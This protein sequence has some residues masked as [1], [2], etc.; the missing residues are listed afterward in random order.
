MESRVTVLER[1]IAVL[2]RQMQVILDAVDTNNSSS[3]AAAAVVEPSRKGLVFI[4]VKP[5]NEK[6][7]NDT[8]T[9]L[10]SAF[11]AAKIQNAEIHILFSSGPRP[12]IPSVRPSRRP[13]IGVVYGPSEVR[14]DNIST[15]MK[16]FYLKTDSTFQKIDLRAEENRSTLQDVVSYLRE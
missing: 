2:K 11:D 7:F 12:D 9:Y 8:S 14:T 10:K 15:S 13:A 3:A 1:E 16:W 6:G 5:G 4:N